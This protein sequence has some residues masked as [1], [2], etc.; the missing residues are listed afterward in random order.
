[1]SYPAHGTHV[2]QGLDVVIFSA[3]KRYMTVEKTEFERTKRQKMDKTNF[4][5]IYA[6]AHVQAFTEANIK[7]AFRVTGLW[8]FNRAAITPA[9]MAPS[10]E[11]AARGHLPVAPSTPVRA[12]TDMMYQIHNAAKRPRS[13]TPDGSRAGPSSR[14]TRSLESLLEGSL[15]TIRTSTS[16]F[17][18]T[19]SPVQSTSAPPAFNLI[20]LSPHKRKKARYSGL[21]AVVPSNIIE[22]ELQNSVR[23]LLAA[24]KQQKSQLVQMQSSLV[25]NGA[26]CDLVRGQLAAQEESKKEKKKG[27]LVGDGMPRLLTATAFVRRVEEFHKTVEAKAS[28]QAERRVTRED[29]KKGM[30]E[31]QELEQ[32]RKEENVAIRARWK[33]DVKAW[34]VERDRA[35]LLHK[36]PSWKKPTLKG[37]LFSA[38]P[39]PAFAVSGSDEPPVPGPSNTTQSG[40]AGSKAADNSG[41]ETEEESEEEESEEES[42]GSEEEEQDSDV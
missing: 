12:V 11:T 21:L 8:P 29:K 14:P 36:R 16:A 4:L 42:G 27:R 2:Y 32:V 26:Y 39:K 5:Q 33:A 38:V 18:I 35:K 37:Q 7:A 1:M 24:N 3:L 23:E 9:M 6:R 10:L 30:A 41:D 17:L 28:Q 25:L 22:E 40:P 34:E 19:S 15:E 31:W 13:R 20:P